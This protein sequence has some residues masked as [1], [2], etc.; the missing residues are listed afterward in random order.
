MCWGCIDI[1]LTTY[2]T[3]HT[4]AYEEI[5]VM[6]QEF[7]GAVADFTRYEHHAGRGELKGYWQYTQNTRFGK[8]VN[9]SIIHIIV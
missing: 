5:V 3:T 9:S 2:Y 7:S 8:I 1:D 4:C 6:L